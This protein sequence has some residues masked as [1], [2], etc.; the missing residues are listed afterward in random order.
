MVLLVAL[1][2]KACQ[3]IVDAVEV[4]GLLIL[5]GLLFINPVPG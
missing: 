2:K 1:Q 3:K 5:G 4:S